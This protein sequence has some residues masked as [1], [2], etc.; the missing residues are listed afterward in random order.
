VYLLYLGR[1]FFFFFFVNS[2][3]NIYG[4]PTMAEAVAGWRLMES[5]GACVQ[6]GFI[7]YYARRRRLS[8]DSTSLA[9]EWE[10]REF[11]WSGGE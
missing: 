10:L 4:Y 9:K 3:K 1:H 2:L 11:I 7:E 5:D 8:R 6:F